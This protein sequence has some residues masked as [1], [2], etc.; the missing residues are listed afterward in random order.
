M[1]QTTVEYCCYD[2][3]KA[4]FPG[5]DNEGYGSLISGDETGWH[6]GGM[7]IDQISFCPWCGVRLPAWDS[8]AEPEDVRKALDSDD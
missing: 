7:D 1:S 2:F 8:K 6:T 3:K 4:L 5:T